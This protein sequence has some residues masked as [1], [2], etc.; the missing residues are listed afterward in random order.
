M[1]QLHRP[2]GDQVV[3]NHPLL[4]HLGQQ[5]HQ[6]AEQRFFDLRREPLTDL[7]D[8][9]VKLRVRDEVQCFASTAEVGFEVGSVALVRDELDRMAERPQTAEVV[10]REDRLTSVHRGGILRHD[11]DLQRPRAVMT[12]R[13]DEAGRA[14][15]RSWS[16]RSAR[17]GRCGGSR[18]APS[19]LCVRCPG[20]P[21]TC[22]PARHGL[23]SRRRLPTAVRSR[24]S[25][26][27]PVVQTRRPDGVRATAMRGS[28]APRERNAE[29]MRRVFIV[30]SS[31]ALPYAHACIRTMLANSV[32]PVH[33]RIIADDSQ[34]QAILA[35]ATSQYAVPG[36]AEIDVIDEQ[37]VADCIATRFPGMEGLRALHTGHPC[38]RKVIDPLALSGP[39]EEI[40]VADPDLFFPNKFDFESTPHHGVMMMRQRPNCLLPTDAVRT[41]FDQGLLLADH[42][43]IGVAQLRAGSIDPE[44]L[45]WAVLT[46][47]P[48]SGFATSCT[49]RRSSGRP[50]RCGSAGYTWIRRSG[51]VGRGAGS[52]GWRWRPEFR[53][54]GRCDGS[55]LL[56]SSAFM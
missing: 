29:L 27:P 46:T 1:D 10:H 36:W 26:S 39:D 13:G 5:E 52:R 50:S 35:E 24:L 28:S 31:R 40:I 20:T 12:G 11:E 21:A 44:W 19:P 23:D 43:D 22:R 17:A 30:M 32:E 47:W 3:A 33:L 14:W 9:A 53:G 56:L 37:D 42:V 49:S 8:Q 4:I 6:V 16:T 15:S 18:H 51:V 41:A 34:E 38:W 55:P 48:S 25:T 45:N 7:P 2:R 54:S